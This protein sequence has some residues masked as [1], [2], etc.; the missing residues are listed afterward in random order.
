MTWEP[1]RRHP[2]ERLH[3]TFISA[4]KRAGRYADG[5]GLYLHVDHS[6]A[7]RWMIRTV[8]QGKRCD[9]GLGGIRTM[10]LE[11]ARALATYL[12]G[13]ARRGGDALALRREVIGN[14]REREGA[15]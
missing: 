2:H 6:G 4:V 9:I 13:Y 1:K 3:P 8:V 12:R 15:R 7:K 11:G 10:S 5:N 14:W